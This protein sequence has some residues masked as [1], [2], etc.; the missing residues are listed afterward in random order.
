MNNNTDHPLLKDSPQALF[1]AV[2]CVQQNYRCY[3]TI[4]HTAILISQETG[5]T[6]LDSDIIQSAYT[7]VNPCSSNNAFRLRLLSMVNSP[8]HKI[9]YHELIYHPLFPLTDKQLSRIQ[10]YFDGQ[11]VFD[12]N[13]RCKFIKRILL[14][15]PDEIEHTH[16]V[17]S[18]LDA[19]IV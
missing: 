14:D 17:D 16:P 1:D 2:Y 18:E 4:L 7:R 10:K 19:V 3:Q 12:I 9:N 13:K 11:W 8:I 15:L 6:I 5:K